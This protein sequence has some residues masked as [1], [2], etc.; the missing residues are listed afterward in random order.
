MKMKNLMY[1]NLMTLGLLTSVYT[2][3]MMANGDIEDSRDFTSSLWYH[4]NV[5]VLPDFT[6]DMKIH[7]LNGTD[8]RVSYMFFSEEI[9]Y[10]ESDGSRSICLVCRR[11]IY[12]DW[13]SAVI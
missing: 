7:N 11:H 4:P 6:D 5:N 3:A 10:G 8:S 12:Y 13:H 9:E 2:F 1:I